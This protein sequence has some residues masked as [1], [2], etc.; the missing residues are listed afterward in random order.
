MVIL[1][2]GEPRTPDVFAVL[3]HNLFEGMVVAAI[4]SNNASMSA[5]V[6]TAG[7]R[8]RRPIAF[9]DLRGYTFAPAR[10]WALDIPFRYGIRGATLGEIV[11][12]PTTAFDG[13]VIDAQAPITPRSWEV[14]NATETGTFVKYLTG[15]AQRTCNLSIVVTEEDEVLLRGVMR[16]IGTTDKK[17]LVIPSSLHPEALWAQSV[18]RYQRVRRNHREFS[19]SLD[20]LE[21]TLGAV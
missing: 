3:C 6:V 15:T 20:L 5:P 7:F 18:P 17:L 19:T 9:V 12:G 1:D 11:I 2:L 16:E 21:E 14:T 4:G 13:G 10:Y 8:A